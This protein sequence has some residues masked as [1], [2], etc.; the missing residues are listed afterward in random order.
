[1]SAHLVKG[2]D[3]VLRNEAV[4]TLVDELLGEADRMLAVEDFEVPGKAAEGELTGADARVAIVDAAL[5]AAYTPPFMTDL[6]V[7]ILRE[8]GNLTKDEA[9]PLVTYLEDPTPT[10]ELVV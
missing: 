1:M 5:N 9:A 3:P 7:V 6:R 8:V 4:H 10:T 2:S